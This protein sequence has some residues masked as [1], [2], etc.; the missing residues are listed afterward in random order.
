MAAPKKT[1]SQK[2]KPARSGFKFFLILVVV[3]MVSFFVGIYR[4][5]VKEIYQ[6]QS[7]A[8]VEGVKEGYGL[9]K[10]GFEWFIPRYN[11]FWENIGKNIDDFVDRMTT[12]RRIPDVKK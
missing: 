12:S 5:Q 2:K 7:P 4:T 6:E 10:R 3:A 9:T 1:E 11:Q 8:V